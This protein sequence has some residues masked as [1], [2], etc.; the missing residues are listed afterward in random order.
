M[1]R[2]SDSI[3]G[4]P[5]LSGFP[6]PLGVAQAFWLSLFKELEDFQSSLLRHD[7]HRL[8]PATHP[9]EAVFI[10]KYYIPDGKAPSSAHNALCLVVWPLSKLQHEIDTCCDRGRIPVCPVGL[11][12]VMDEDDCD[13]SLSRYRADLVEQWLPLKRGSTLSYDAGCVV[14]KGIHHDDACVGGCGQ[15]VERNYSIRA[16]RP[17]GNA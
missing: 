1:E 15:V 16:A 2:P 7:G 11:I 14:R 10:L 13:F 3:E 5:G 17:H 8:F 12:G 4:T 9:I 6:E